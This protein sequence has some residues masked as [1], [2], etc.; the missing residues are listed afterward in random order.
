[1]AQR[2]ATGMGRGEVPSPSLR[3]ARVGACG[4]RWAEVVFSKVS[5]PLRGCE[6]ERGGSMHLLALLLVAAAPLPSPDA[7]GYPTTRG[8]A[9]V[10]FLLPGGGEPRVGGTYF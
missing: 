10:S 1:M 4:A 5:E 9:G 3:W 6:N 2:A 7:D 8:T